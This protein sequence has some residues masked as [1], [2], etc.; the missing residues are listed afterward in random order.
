MI[1]VTVPGFAEYGFEHLVLDYN[2]TLAIDGSLIPLVREKLTA[3]AQHL[4]VHV[5]TADTFGSAA[6][7]L[8][9]IPCSL[10]VVASESQDV[11]KREYVRNLGVQKCVC[12]GNGRN[13]RKMLHA[14]ALGIAVIQKEGAS[15]ES[16]NSAQIICGNIIDALELLE[17]SK[18]LAATL[19]C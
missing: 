5:L 14:A 8:A 10:T 2:G 13:D 9:D 17:N 18:R 6:K 12:I 3:L 16:I 15:S 1:R 7:Q 19:R 4:T 11:I